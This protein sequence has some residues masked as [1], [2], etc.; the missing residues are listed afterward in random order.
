MLVLL[1]T[2]AVQLAL[3]LRYGLAADRVEQQTALI[4]SRA[5]PRAGTIA[6]APAQ[7]ATRLAELRGGGLG[8]GAT[9]AALF[10]AVRDSANVELSALSFERDGSLHATASAAS[11]ADLAALE[12]RIE[13]Q[14]F[15]VEAGAAQPGGGRQ[16]AELTMRAR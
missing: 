7:L 16:I 10:G 12:S 13:A 14:G 6:N 5:V 15:T 4:A 2:L 9:A 3:I 11:A 1:A 8:F